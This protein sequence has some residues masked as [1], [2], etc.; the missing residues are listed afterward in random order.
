[1]KPLY[2][3][4][5][6]A[7]AGSAFWLLVALCRELEPL[8][9]SKQLTIEVYD[10]DN[11]IGGNGSKRLPEPHN[12]DQPKVEYLATFIKH[13]M[14]NVPPVIHARKLVPSDF[15][16]E[17][18][19]KTI[20]V[21][22]TDMGRVARELFWETLDE[23]EIKGIRLALDGA[24]ISTIS[25]GP[26]IYMGDEEEQHNEYTKTPHLGQVFRSVGGG[27]EAVIYLLYTGKVLER[28][29]FMP[30]PENPVNALSTV[31]TFTQQ[32]E[33]V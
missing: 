13:V 5:V 10:D 3:R 22:A 1:M 23:Y 19:S 21:D 17:D 15:V 7:G 16:D 26:P 20:V 25:P 29:D 12:P 31:L 33:G 2:N 24:G 30:T 18:W 14:G 6:I 11:F 9:L 27:A 32:E 28:D 8:V 4:I